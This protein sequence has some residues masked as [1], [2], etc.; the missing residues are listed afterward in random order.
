[1]PFAGGEVGHRTATLCQLNVIAMQLGRTLKWDPVAE[2][3]INDDEANK[4]LM[5]AMRAPWALP[6][7]G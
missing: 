4:L 3:V 5:P 2:R 6:E 1:M 7:I